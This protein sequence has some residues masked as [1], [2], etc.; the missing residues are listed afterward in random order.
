MEGA[1]KGYFLGQEIP[2]QTSFGLPG[3]LWKT[4]PGFLRK[5]QKEVWHLA[6]GAV[7]PHSRSTKTII[8]RPRADIHL[9][10]L[11]NSTRRQFCIHRYTWRLY[12]VSEIIV[13]GHSSV[14][15]GLNSPG[16]PSLTRCTHCMMIRSLILRWHRYIVNGTG[17]SRVF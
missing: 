12:Q 16:S 8:N 14:A 17:Y 10:L 1:A 4:T 15:P 5:R 9:L 2:K 11:T 3:A 6:G 7:A 13:K